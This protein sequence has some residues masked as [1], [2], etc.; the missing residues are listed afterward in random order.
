M[1]RFFFCFACQHCFVVYS[2]NFYP[3]YV[4]VANCIRLALYFT[5][6]SIFT[7]VSS[8]LKRNPG[9]SVV[10]FVFFRKS[11]KWNTYLDTKI[12]TIF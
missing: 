4:P 1:Y 9:N 8:I 11:S 3:R 2:D 7:V 5:R 12:C 6:F 10:V